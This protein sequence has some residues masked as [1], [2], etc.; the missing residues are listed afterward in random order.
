V[1]KLLLKMFN[2]YFSIVNFFDTSV[3]VCLF[4]KFIIALQL[5][6]LKFILINLHHY[7]D[8]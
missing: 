2:N 6:V 7:S 1:K 3:F 4:V 8:I 5:N